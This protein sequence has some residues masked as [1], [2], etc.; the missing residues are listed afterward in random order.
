MKNAIKSGEIKVQQEA[1]PTS[2][3]EMAPSG[4]PN[5]S[6]PVKSFKTIHQWRTESQEG[7]C[8]V[9]NVNI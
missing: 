6:G 2:G 1:E 4:N 7:S 3:E 8:I 9:N 5:P